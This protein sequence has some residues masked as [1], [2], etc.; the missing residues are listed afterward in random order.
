MSSDQ[1][2]ARMEQQ[3]HTIKNNKKIPRE[4]VEIHSHYWDE[5]KIQWNKKVTT[6]TASCDFS[7]NNGN[8]VYH[9]L[10]IHLVCAIDLFFLRLSKY[11]N[12]I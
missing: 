8:L 3:K 5:C 6:K 2:R 10:S 7:V 11:W 12:T 1:T 4:E 9:S